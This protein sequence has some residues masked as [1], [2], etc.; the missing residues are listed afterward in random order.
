MKLLHVT[1]AKRRRLSETDHFGWLKIFL[2]ALERPTDGQIGLRPLRLR[3][4]GLETKLGLVF[5]FVLDF[6]RKF[7][8]NEEIQND[9]QFFCTTP[10]LF[11]SQDLK[12]QALNC[13]QD[14]EIK[15]EGTEYWSL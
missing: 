13:S 3:D 1:M 6:V 11:I 4:L 2:L 7:H 8:A 9:S 14:P 10:F 15:V 5:L 12:L